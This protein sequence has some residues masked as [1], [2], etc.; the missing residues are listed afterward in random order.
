M[1][2]EKPPEGFNY[3]DLQWEYKADEYG[4]AAGAYSN[5]AKPIAD[6]YWKIVRKIASSTPY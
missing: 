5:Q 2:M 6:L 3:Y 1:Q 4:G